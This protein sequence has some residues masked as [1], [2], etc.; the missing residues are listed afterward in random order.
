MKTFKE[1]ILEKLKI[2][3]IDSA[4]KEVANLWGGIKGEQLAMMKT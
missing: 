1:H 4:A 2:W 3:N